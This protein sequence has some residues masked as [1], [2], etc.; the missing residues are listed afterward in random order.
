[1]LV[2][3]LVDA[4]PTPPGVD[5]LPG[6]GEAVVSPALAARIEDGAG[7]P[8]RRRI[9]VVVGTIGDAGLR[10]PDELVAVIGVDTGRA[11]NARRIADQGVRSTATDARHPTDRGPDD[12]ARGHRCAGPGRGLRLDGD[13]AVGRAPRAAPGRAPTDRRDN[14]PGDATRGRRGAVRHVAG[15]VAGDRPVLPGSAAGRDD[16]A[17][18]GDLVPGFDR[19][20]ARPGSGHA[21]GDPGRRCRRRG[22]RPATRRSHAARRPAPADAA[23]C[24]GAR[25]VVP[26]AAVA[27]RSALRDP[28]ASAAVRPRATSL[29]LL[30]GPRSAA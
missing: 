29:W 2:A 25:R 15:V 10:S 17:R 27:R 11:R 6:P 28:H 13:A 3:G 18:R 4:P 8:A 19:A 7:R 20:A 24:P 1:M 21:R 26:L 22:R 30:S 12:R 14:A 16:P 5:R 23:G 9:G